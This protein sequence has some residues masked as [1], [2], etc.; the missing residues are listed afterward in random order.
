MAD[1]DEDDIFLFKQAIDDTGISCQVHVS[2]NGDELIQSL[3]EFSPAH[4]SLVFLDMNMMPGIV[5][6]IYQEW[7]I[8]KAN[9]LHIS[10]R[11][12]FQQ[13]L[14]MLLRRVKI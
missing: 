4:P 8:T 13:H 12:F 11:N 1:D 2:K 5:M 9:L 14:G 7:L 3:D 6:L 10:V